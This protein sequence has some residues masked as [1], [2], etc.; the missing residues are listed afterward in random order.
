MR[1]GRLQILSVLWVL[2]LIL[3]ISVPYAAASKYS[4]A[5]SLVKLVKVGTLPSVDKRLPLHPLVSNAPQV[6]TYGGTL[7]YGFS[8][9]DL[10]M[11]P[12][13]PV[14]FNMAGAWM[15]STL[16]MVSLSDDTKLEPDLAEKWVVSKDGKVI[17]FYLRNG[18][19]WSDGKP[20]NVDDILFTYNDVILN[21]KMA[22]WYVDTVKSACTVDGKPVKMTKIN[23][24]TFTVTMSKPDPDFIARVFSPSITTMTILPKHEMVKVHPKYNSKATAN[25]WNTFRNPVKKPAVLWPWVPVAHSGNRFVWER[26]PYYWR[27]DRKGQQ[28]PYVD[29]FVQWNWESSSAAALAVI[30]GELSGD[31]LGWMAD[32][33]T[34]LKEQEKSRP[35]S[36]QVFNVLRPQAT[37][38]LNLDDED[39]SL[40]T[41]FR[42]IRFKDALSMLFDRASIA[43]KTGILFAPLR[44]IIWPDTAKLAPSVAAK[45][46]VKDDQK[47]GLKLL[48]E[49][50]ITDKDGD[51]WREFPAGT[52]KAGKPLE[53]VVMAGIGDTARLRVAEEVKYQLERLGIKVI[54][55]PQ[56][57]EA[58][59]ERIVT[60]NYDVITEWVLGPSGTT[61][62]SLLVPNAIDST[63]DYVLAKVKQDGRVPPYQPKTAGKDVFPWQSKWMQL[64]DDYTAGKIAKKAAFEKALEIVTPNLPSIPLIA[65]HFM[66]VVRDDIGNYPTDVSPQIRENYWP[67][68]QRDQF[69]LYVY[70]RYWDWYYK[71]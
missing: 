49:I 4:E 30:S 26:N 9:L 34:V 11:N 1:P 67:M 54:L 42:N 60:G 70:V 8:Q 65:M 2:A 14:D 24:Y 7:T 12:Y 66:N 22:G 58:F 29:T 46:D 36:V 61:M 55:N 23:S 51:G 32:Q 31:F 33:A 63:G 59:V 20:F 40:R 28:L 35:Y 47:Q 13:V 3:T 5:P 64:I 52:P 18:V 50:G 10:P 43:E 16:T 56:V 19:K 27:V 48:D 69:N 44:S 68:S 15:S 41:I 39:E 21:D 25:D 53:F 45:Y 71:K 38:I 37:L 62:D 17:T 6:G 57:S